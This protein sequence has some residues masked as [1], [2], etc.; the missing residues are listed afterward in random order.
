[1][2]DGKQG[3]R[4]GCPKKDYLFRLST[5]SNPGSVGNWEDSDIPISEVTN[6]QSG[7]ANGNSGR[8]RC[9]N[10]MDSMSH[11]SIPEDMRISFSE[12]EEAN[13]IQLG[14]ILNTY[15]PAG[16]VDL[17]SGNLST[18]ENVKDDDSQLRNI[19]SAISSTSGS[20]LH[21][22]SSI[23]KQSET[24]IGNGMDR[25]SRPLLYNMVSSDVKSEDL[26][27][28]MFDDGSWKDMINDQQ[29]NIRQDWDISF[30]QLIASL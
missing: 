5:D 25:N 17:N 10:R 22:M 11:M 1:M 3:S 24:N 18:L 16:D 6:G 29:V 21:K 14:D 30:F 2:D 19:S 20:D 26:S 27:E 8:Q 28:S 15:S 7:S 9:Q 23:G 4:K 12:L 13:S